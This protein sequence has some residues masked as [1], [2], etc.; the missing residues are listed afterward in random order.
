MF[1]FGFFFFLFFFTVLFLFIPDLPW[2]K[3]PNGKYY[4]NLQTTANH[5]QNSI[6]LCKDAGGFLQKPMNREENDYLEKLIKGDKNFYL[7]LNDSDKEGSW[8]WDDDGT[9]VM[10][11]DWI[12]WK[13]VR[14]PT[15]DFG[16]DCVN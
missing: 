5:K 4:I 2:E 16:E 9:S 7:G 15:G 12:D 13:T 10:W 6:H 3:G 8:V 11:A 14:E 1:C